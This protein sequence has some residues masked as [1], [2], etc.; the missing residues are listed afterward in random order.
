MLDSKYSSE[1]ELYLCEQ[2]LLEFASACGGSNYDLERN[3]LQDVRG[4]AKAKTESLD[5]IV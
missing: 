4:T 1:T 3:H 2:N 5:L